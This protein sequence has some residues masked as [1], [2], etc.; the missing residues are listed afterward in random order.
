[1][2]ASFSLVLLLVLVLGTVCD[3]GEND[4]V[5]ENAAEVKQEQW[6]MSETN[7][8]GGIHIWRRSIE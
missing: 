3:S 8:K 6:K 1:M 7:T 4:G 2:I 5:F